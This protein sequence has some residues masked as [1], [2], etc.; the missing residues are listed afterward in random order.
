MEQ[1][2]NVAATKLAV[3]NYGRQMRHDWKWLLPGFLLPAIGSI[4]VFYVPPL[5]VA[6]LLSNFN[7]ASDITLSD[8][9]PYLI[10]FVVLWTLGELLWRIAIFLI[11]RAETF[12]SQMLYNQA[13]ESL[14]KKDLAFFHDNFAGSLTKRVTSYSWKYVELIDTMT[15]SVFSNY[16]P[17]IFVAFILW[18]FSPWLVLGLLGLMTITAFI[19]IPLIRRRQRLVAVRE[20]ASTKM[21]GYT[22]DI[23][24]NIDTVKAFANE[25]HEKQNYQMFFNDMITKAKHSWDYQNFRID[26]ILSPFSIIT[27]SV[28]LLLSIWIANRSAVRLEVVFVTF[29]YYAG[30]TRSMWEFNHVYR[31]IESAITEGAQYTELTI[32]EPKVQD[33]AKPKPFTVNNGEIE[34]RGVDF[35]YQEDGSEHLFKNFN[36][37]IKPGEKVALVGHSGGGKTTVTRLLLRFMDIQGGQILIDGQ[38]IAEVRQNDL[39]SKVAYVPQ[40]P[41]MFHRSLTDNIRYGRLDATEAEVKQAAKDAH[42]TEFID[43]LP[44]GYKTLVGE[45]GIKLSGGQRQRIAVARAMVKDAPILVLDEATSALDSESEKY[46]QDA[47]WKLME[48]RTVIVIAHRLSTIQRMDRIVVLEDGKIA[49]EGSHKELL[50]NKGIYSTLWAHQSGGFLED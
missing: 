1:S 44:Q 4:L 26:S 3:K 21:T 12:G 39:R 40:E 16:L 20:T 14:L 50:K 22:A 30:V 15:F 35:R 31:N 6:R 17:I 46:I 43:K 23:F 25:G 13:M 2:R 37:K 36:L 24:S 33:V 42:A 41:A 38:N 9:A 32:D 48:G 49:E 34:L 29:N 18:Q 11:I 8:F 27:N 10:I 28:G 47:L 19:V 45:R 7:N 5:I